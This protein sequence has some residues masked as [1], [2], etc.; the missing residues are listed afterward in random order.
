MKMKITLEEL[1]KVMEETG[2][3]YKAAKEALEKVGGDADAAIRSMNTNGSEEINKLVEKV[4]ALVR[5]GNVSR[6]QISRK[7]EV[8]LSLPVNVG[9]GAG[10]VGLLAFPWAMVAGVIA[11]Y[12]LDCRIEVIKDDGSKDEIS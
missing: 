11:A 9:I 12:G 4:K 1:E 7:D 3:D 6:I 10:L 2:L 5:E 8:I